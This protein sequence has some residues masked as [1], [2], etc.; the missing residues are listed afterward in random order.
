MKFCSFASMKWLLM[1]VLATGLAGMVQA[2]RPGELPGMA[3]DERR[4]FFQV[5]FR[6][7]DKTC[8]IR[9]TFLMGS[10]S[11]VGEFWSIRCADNISWVISVFPDGRAGV[12][13]CS[14][15]QRKTGRPCFTKF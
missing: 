12:L 11:S 7:T 4:R 5:V 3:E 15:M 13:E 9:E 6:L 1:L 14:V 10:D 8:D 2:A